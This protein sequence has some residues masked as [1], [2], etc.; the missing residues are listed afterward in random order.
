MT[1]P[2]KV[3]ILSNAQ[4]YDLWLRLISCADLVAIPD[5]TVLSRQ[6]S[7]QDSKSEPVQAKREYRKLVSQ[8]LRAV[9]FI[10][11]RNLLDW[12]RI[13]RSLI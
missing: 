1:E 4:A 3:L 10:D 8:N 13:A 5:A 9:D 12:I 2:T 6:H 11:P 7:E